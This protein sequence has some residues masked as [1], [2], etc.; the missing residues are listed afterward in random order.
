MQFNLNGMTDTTQK[1]S[2][3]CG[4]VAEHTKCKEIS[5]RFGVP[6]TNT[7]P[8]G[9]YYLQW[10]ADRLELRNADESAAHP[11]IVDFVS[12]KLA[13]RRRY[14][15]GRRQ[16]LAR[17][18][19]IK[20]GRMPD[21]WDATAGL[22]RDSFVLASLGLNITLC[23]R[24]PALAAL[25]EDGLRRA[26]LDSEIGHWIAER[27]QLCF[28]DS[29]DLLRELPADQCPDTIYLD[30]MYPHGKGSALV[31]KDM[32]AL[33]QMLGPDIDSTAVFEQALATAQQRV[34]VKRPARANWLATRKPDAVINSKKTR[35]DI[36][37]SGNTGLS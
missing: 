25:L 30:P 24:S 17:A 33:Q 2:L 36:Y 15:G 26:K 6:L 16:P 27:M 34:V 13:H 29:A 1:I 3:L 21:V 37:F 19:G 22:G 8:E 32:R 18:I 11:V 5:R 23:E 20:P 9:G 10:Q 14:G 31:K 12:G 35:Y 7:L 28:G 4:N